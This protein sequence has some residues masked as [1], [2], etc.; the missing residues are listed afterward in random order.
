[1]MQVSYRYDRITPYGEA[2][3]N[4]QALQLEVGYRSLDSLLTFA[5]KFYNG[6]EVRGEGTLTLR[7]FQRVDL[8]STLQ[9]NRFL[10]T[11]KRAILLNLAYRMDQTTRPG[12]ESIP[13]VD[14]Q[15][16]SLLAGLDIEMKKHWHL[17]LGLQSVQYRGSDFVEERDAYG[18]IYN[19]NL[20]KLD[21]K[22][23]IWAIGAKHAF[24]S[25]AYLT[26]QYSR[27]TNQQKISNE[28]NHRL[29]QWMLLYNI[30]F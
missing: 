2:T 10:K 28:Q 6:K 15:N 17:L 8:S 7:S 26:F 5:G 19:F 18:S 12:T 30:S 14:L 23:S 29:G 1:L 4:R 11:W 13:A 27:F 24:S 16:Q 22:E 21:G 9:I 25:D 20:E 3:P